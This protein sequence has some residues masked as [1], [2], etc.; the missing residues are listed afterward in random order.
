MTIARPRTV[1]VVFGTRPD[2]V[3]MAP[4]VQALRAAPA[5]FTP[6][7]AV[8]AQHREMLDQVLRLFAIAPD[9]DLGIMTE[10]Q[11]LA[12]ITVRTLEGLSALLPRVAPDLVLVQGD[13]APSFVGSL[14]AFY[15]RIPVGHVE[16]GLRTD[17]KYQPFPEEMYRRMTTVL[18]DIHFAPT[19]QARRN[20]IVDGVPAARILVTG[21]TVIDAL[22]DVA[23]RDRPPADP[24]LAA[25][26]NRPGRRVL[27]LT[28][29]RRENWGEPQRRIFLAVRDLLDRFP[30]LDLVF[31]VHPNPVV[32][33]PAHELLGRHPRAYLCEPVDYAAN[34]ACM[35]AA[36]LILTDSGGIQEEAPALGRPVLVLRETTE[37]P[38]GI[39]AGTA[40][41]VGTDRARIVEV[42]ARLLTDPAAYARMSRARNPY[43]DG[44]AAGRIVGGLRYFFG[45]A[46]NPPAEFVVRDTAAP[47]RTARRVPAGAKAR[48]RQ[49]RPR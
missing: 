10:K 20:L 37:R 45:L 32:A 46:R 48:G 22:L 36:A 25:V 6:V 2:A 14:A 49:S 18:A 26:L 17:D 39:A 21:N 4:V 23:R 7:V 40:H 33:G 19:P 47:T 44:R 30:D 41:L 3:K 5:E 11:S 43:G 12:D 27:L 1:M 38:E 8:T 13:A 29:H 16:A 9:H 15:Q 34:V 31:P 28:S 42:A 35:K 24:A